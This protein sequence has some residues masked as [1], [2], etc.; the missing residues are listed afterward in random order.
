M[1]QVT[2][3]ENYIVHENGEVYSLKTK[4]FLTRS[5]SLNGYQT[6][7]INNKNESLH[8]IMAKC[9]LPKIDGKNCVN[10]IDGN[11]KNNELS[12]LEWCNHKE[13]SRH[14]WNNGLK[15]YHENTRK[16]N[17]IAHSRLVLNLETGIF[18]QSAKEAAN[19][20]GIKEFT[21]RAMLNGK[22]K[23][24]TSFVYA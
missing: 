17:S 4:R 24:R 15:L 5:N 18:Y 21:F 19:I 12:N 8:R 23:N 7:S 9:F 14:A 1:K 13:N 20:I 2:Y 3:K 10:H 6:V 16:G 11:K 22:F